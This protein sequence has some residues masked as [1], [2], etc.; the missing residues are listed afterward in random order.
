MSN[1]L[2]TLKPTTPT[3]Y[4]HLC[5]IAGKLRLQNMSEYDTH[6]IEPLPLKKVAFIIVCQ[7][8][9]VDGS[10]SKPE[11]D[12][13]YNND[14]GNDAWVT[15]LTQSFIDRTLAH[16]PSHIRHCL[17]AIWIN[18]RQEDR[19]EV[20]RSARGLQ[21]LYEKQIR[22]LI[23]GKDY[24]TGDLDS[25]QEKLNYNYLSKC[26][27]FALLFKTSLIHCFSQ[28]NRHSWRM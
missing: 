6:D 16:F 28:S 5:N 3:Y 25:D 22:H 10:I 8:L 26:R 17:N 15:T 9:E 19:L 14:S 7:S 20:S 24:R 4:K 23:A 11:E 12:T 2:R 27:F 1:S 18:P 21:M 13:V